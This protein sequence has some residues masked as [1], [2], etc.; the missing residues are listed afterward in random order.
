MRCGSDT[1]ISKFCPL[2][3][4]I[5]MATGVKATLDALVRGMTAALD[6]KASKVRLLNE[7]REALELAAVYGLGEGYLDREPIKLTE[8]TTDARV[9]K[10]EIVSV[11]DAAADEEGRYRLAAEKEGIRSVLC[12]PLMVRDKAMGVLRIY[13]AEQR[14]WDGDELK[15]ASTVAGLA[16]VAL[17]KA[18]LWDRIQALMDAARAVSSTLRLSEVLDLVVGNAARV[19]GFKG[20]SVRLL[21]EDGNMLELAATSGLSRRYLEKGAVEVAKSPIDQE[22]LRGDVVA[23]EDVRVD[24]RL[25]YPKEVEREGIRSVLCMPLKVKDRAIGVLRVYASVPRKFSKVETDFLTALASQCA[26]AIE[27]ARLFEHVRRDYDDL[28]RDVWKWYDWG[29]HP[30]RL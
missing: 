17:E 25:Q 8:G 3:Q 12:L 6:A 21:D 27:N 4:E 24:S 9:L 15:I 28:T 20:A 14:K 26:V 22:C 7:E 19:L 11:E 2:C 16:G 10:G 5:A 29:A 30:P 1:H 23:V 18:K 13:T